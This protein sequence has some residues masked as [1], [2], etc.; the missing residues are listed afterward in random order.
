MNR[1]ALFNEK[2][3]IFLVFHKKSQEIYKTVFAGNTSGSF[4]RN[5]ENKENIFMIVQQPGHGTTA[6]GFINDKERKQLNFTN[7]YLFSDQDV[8]SYPDPKG[9]DIECLQSISLTEGDQEIAM[10]TEVID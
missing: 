2:K 5:Q 7:N 1:L 3:Q 4:V 6:I 10:K 8:I 9:S